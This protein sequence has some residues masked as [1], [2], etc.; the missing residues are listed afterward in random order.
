VATVGRAE[1]IVAIEMLSD[2]GEATLE[3]AVAVPAVEL[4]DEAGTQAPVD[5]TVMPP[6][7]ASML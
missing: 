7:A 5:G 2:A 3:V 4:P 1:L 6:S